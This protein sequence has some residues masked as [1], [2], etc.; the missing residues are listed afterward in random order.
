MKLKWVTLTR[1]LTVQDIHLF[2]LMSGDVNPTH[3]DVE[4]AQS[5]MFQK[6]S[7]HSLW[8]AALIS[9]LLGTELPGPG[10]FY[11]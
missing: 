11:R 8:S 1:T 6:L 5:S 2:A 9:S 7:G 10:T 3:I 4:Y